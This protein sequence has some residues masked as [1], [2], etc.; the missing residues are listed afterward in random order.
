MGNDWSRKMVQADVRNMDTEG[1]AEEFRNHYRSLLHVSRQV[2][3]YFGYA[4]L[5]QPWHDEQDPYKWIKIPQQR[6]SLDKILVRLKRADIEPWAFYVILM[7]ITP[8]QYWERP[9]LLLYQQPFIAAIKKLRTYV[10]SSENLTK[11]AQMLME[12]MQLQVQATG[13]TTLNLYNVSSKFDDV[14]LAKMLKKGIILVGYERL[15]DKIRQV[16]S[17]GI[18]FPEWMKVRQDCCKK[19]ISRIKDY[20]KN[21]NVSLKYLLRNDT[22]G[23]T[24]T[25]FTDKEKDAWS[26]V[27]E[28]LGLSAGCTFPDGYIPKG[29]M[30]QSDDSENA[31]SVVSVTGDGFYYKADGTQ[32]RGNWHHMHNK[33]MM[34]KCTPENFKLFVDMWRN[35]A[36]RNS[37]PTWQNYSAWARYPNMWDKDGNGLV[38]EGGQMIKNVKWRSAERTR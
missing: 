30:L 4:G 11:L 18:S 10:G 6:K 8:Y 38:L 37:S 24:F 32:R 17:K 31:D 28:F 33:Y 12:F 3:G 5:I 20:D 14:P 25:Y 2:W 9:A 21:S 26:A 23:P 1:Q 19:V 22:A 16:E 34:I 29:F 36:T 27:R 7:S 35:C 13:R 15:W